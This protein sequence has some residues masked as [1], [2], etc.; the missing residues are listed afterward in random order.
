LVALVT[1]VELLEEGDQQLTVRSGFT[2]T[3][4]KI[5]F[6]QKPIKLIELIKQSVRIRYTLCLEQSQLIL[7][8]ACFF[9]SSLKALRNSSLFWR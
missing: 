6:N 2:E 3:G 1:L 9:R 4:V 8:L 5:S 7:T